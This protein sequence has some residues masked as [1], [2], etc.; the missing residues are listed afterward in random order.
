MRTVRVPRTA[1]GGPGPWAAPL[2][3]TLGAA[4]RVGIACA[5]V[6][7]AS[8]AWTGSARAAAVD[9]IS[10]Q[11]L[12][13]W[14]TA[15]GT[16][17]EGN[18]AASPFA[19][20][21]HEV[22]ATGS[23]VKY[24]RYV[25]QWNAKAGEYAA[26]ESWYSEVTQDLHL[27]PVLA[28][29]NFRR[30]EEANPGETE[31]RTAIAEVLRAHPRIAAVEAWNEPNGNGVSEAAAARY[32][33]IA[34]DYCRTAGC[35]VLAGDFIDEPHSLEYARRYK[36]DLGAA[37]RRSMKEWALHPYVAV[38]GGGAQ[39]RAMRSSVL[40]GD[41]LWI[42]EIGAYYCEQP[43][44]EPA[45]QVG[46]EQQRARADYLVDRV[47]PAL[48]PVHVFYY[49]VLYKHLT[50]TPCARGQSDTALYNPDDQTRKAARVIFEGALPRLVGGEANALLAAAN[51]G[52]SLANWPVASEEERTTRAPGAG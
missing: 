39:A 15:P 33:Q 7:C 43:E 3:R 32:A 12:P 50:L 51:P 38:N 24:A 40:A 13:F 44:A 6:A 27:T 8:I 22:W 25:L 9:G 37:Y 28:L 45:Q 2:S 41:D 52:S 35:I 42:T 16:G 26:F 29:Y 47:I 31:Y 20:Y 11:N 21:F 10:D 36:Q 17:W 4:A 49:E 23:H 48:R 34:F 30:R 1:R 14:D 18:L 46:E 19:Q 5:A